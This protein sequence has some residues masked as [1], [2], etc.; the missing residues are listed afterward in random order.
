MAS[1]WASKGLKAVNEHVA[2][3]PNFISDGHSHRAHL[4][5]C[6]L[7][8][9]ETKNPLTCTTDAR[10]MRELAQACGISDI[11]E[12]YNLQ[13]TKEAVMYKIQ[14]MASS[15]ED[16]D[17]F[18][19]YYSGHGTSIEDQDGDEEDG[20]DEAFCFVDSRGQITRSTCMTDD[21]FAHIVTSSVPEHARILVLTDCCHSGTIC[22]FDRP[23]WAGREAVCIAG[24]AD[25][26]TSGDMGKGGI[27]THSMLLAI[28]KLQRSAQ[29]HDYSVGLLYNASVHEDNEIFK[30]A[31]DITLKCPPG[32]SPD[33][34]CWPFIPHTEYQAPLRRAAETVANSPMAQSM[35]GGAGD[36]GA[37]FAM[38][39]QNPEMLQQLGISL[40]VLHAVQ[41]MHSIQNE[42]GGDYVDALIKSGVL[43]QILEACSIM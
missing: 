36:A 1:F 21:E 6:A 43:C 33:R 12:L 32:F 17:Y 25:S 37:L 4:L 35:P 10:N 14:E 15:V 23:D 3:G 20:E 31:Q 5:I 41:A 29:D 26:Q 42:P 28:D 27:F 40:E 2:S 39:A 34:M 13:C 9:K 30:S 18:V 7:D 19:F 8:Y 22:D 38:A 16:D 11:R 24:C